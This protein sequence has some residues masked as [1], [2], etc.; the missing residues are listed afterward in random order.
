MLYRMRESDGNHYVSGNWIVPARP[1]RQLGPADIKMIPGALVEIDGH[2]LPVSWQ[3]AIPQLSLSIE[4]RALN[5]RAW[6]GTSFAYWEGP[7]GFSGSHTGV[8]YLELTGY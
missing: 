4:C 6:N 3:I 2:K 7:I 5:E 8:G 1:A